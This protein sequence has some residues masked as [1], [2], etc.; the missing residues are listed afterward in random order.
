M[1]GQFL[2]KKQG[3]QRYWDVI[4]KE[5]KEK[6]YQPRRLLYRVKLFFKMKE[7]FKFFISTKAEGVNH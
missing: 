3:G 7:K 5:L 4:F 2:I 1:I 6:S